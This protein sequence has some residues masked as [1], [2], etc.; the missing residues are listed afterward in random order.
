MRE[1][2]IKIH[3]I[4]PE[5]LHLSLPFSEAWWKQAMASLQ[6]DL[7]ASGAGADVT[8]TELG[9]GYLVRGQIHGG[10]Q[11][12]CAR[13][14]EPAQIDLSMPI[15]TTFTRG[16][17]EPEAIDD[18][19]EDVDYSTFEGDEIDLGELF[20]EQMLLAVPMTPLCREDCKGL[21]PQCGQD[22]N[23]GS[24]TCTQ[25]TDPR[26]ESLKGLKA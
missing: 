23:Q 8:V 24:C 6:M 15:L 7:A 11:V 20:R 26:W 4:G 18:E 12:P 9:S 16:A 1:M 5:G 2:K 17:D 14:L 19:D 10:A 3:E 21:C 22:R 25:P 13:C